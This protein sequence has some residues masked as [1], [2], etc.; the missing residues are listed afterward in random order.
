[1]IAI[2]ADI[3]DNLVYLGKLLDWC[4]E[5][6]AEDLI[7]CGDVTNIDTLAEINHRFRGQIHLVRGNMDIYQD[8]ELKKFHG[9]KNFHYY[10]R[11]GTFEIGG[12]QFGLCHQPFLIDKALD[13]VPCDFVFYGHTHKPWIESRDNSIIV[14]PGTL[15]GVFQKA[16]FATLE[17]EKNDLQLRTI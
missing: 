4:D 1:M 17:M 8:E 12:K 15:G 5:N 9:N 13:T 6:L 14:N 3:H 7:C 10:G 16:T 2:I 11:I